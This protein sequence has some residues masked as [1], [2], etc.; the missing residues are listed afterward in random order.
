MEQADRECIHFQLIPDLSLFIKQAIY[1]NYLGDMPVLTPRREPLNDIENRIKK[2]VFDLLVSLMVTV[3]ILWWLIPALTL[4]I[5]I[6]SRG[7]VFFV[8][9]RTGRNNRTFNC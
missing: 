4:I 8:Q 1:V 5:L 7:P 3:F 9:Q 6:D 2:R